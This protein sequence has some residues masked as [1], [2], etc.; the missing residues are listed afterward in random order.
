V[1]VRKRSGAIVTVIALAFA[2]ALLI[3]N[4]ATTGRANAQTPATPAGK[5]PPYTVRWNRA[6]GD[7]TKAIVEVS[8]LD[9]GVLAKLAKAAWTFAE[10]HELLAVS[11]TQDNQRAGGGSVPMAGRYAIDGGALRFEPRFPLEPGLA[12]VARFHPV[13]LPGATREAESV[14]V[15]FRMPRREASRTT[16]VTQI[17][18]TTAVVPENLLKFYL[19][20]SAPMSRGHIY[21]HIHLLNEAGQAIELPFLEIDEELWDPAMTRLTL[22]IDPGRIK[23]GVRPLEE[24]GPALET[25]NAYTLLIDDAWTDANGNALRESFRKKFRVGPVD[26]EPPDP[27]QWKIEAPR[28]NTM[29]PVIILFP[30]PM[31]RALAERLIRITTAAEG[32]AIEGNVSLSEEERRW[33]FQPAQRWRRGSFAVV[34]QTTIEDLAGNNIGKPFEVDVV[35]TTQARLTKNFVKL[36]FEVR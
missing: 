36:P 15:I 27:A 3:G 31:D 14:S 4:S 6:A 25:G 30:D 29:D 9:S 26:R 16:I 11:V 17:F 35:E 20:F 18:P 33:S 8:G 12:Y 10:W 13:K 7:D 23:R 28:I 1:T 19:H 24:I 22:F 2:T 34:V 21:D 32:K 5:I